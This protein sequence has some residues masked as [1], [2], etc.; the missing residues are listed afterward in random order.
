MADHLINGVSP[1]LQTPAHN[2]AHDLLLEAADCIGARAEQRDQPDGERSMRRTVAAFNALYGTRLT[3]LQG[4][5]FMALLKMARAAGGRVH[6]DDFIDQAAYA[7]LAGE[8]A[9]GGQLDRDVARAL[10]LGKP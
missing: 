7:A 5:Q 4:W 9:L 6:R 3:E 2:A 10:G 1:E 8:C